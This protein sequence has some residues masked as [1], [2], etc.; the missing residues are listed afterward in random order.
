MAVYLSLF[1]SVVVVAFKSTF[2]SEIYQNDLKTPKNIK[3]KQRKK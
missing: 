3:L 1:E 2:H